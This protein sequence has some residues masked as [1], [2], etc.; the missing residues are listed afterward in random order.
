MTGLSRTTPHPS[1]PAAHRVQRSL[2]DH[3][4]AISADVLGDSDMSG[5]MLAARQAILDK[6]QV[7][8]RIRSA[9]LLALMWNVNSPHILAFWL[10]LH[11]LSDETLL[12]HIQRETGKYVKV[13]QEAPVMGFAV[14][15][16]VTIDAEGLLTNCPL[17]K[18]A[19]IETVRL[20]SRGLLARKAT[21]SFV[22]EARI[23]KAFKKGDRWAIRKGEFIDVPFWIANTD[24][25]SF[26]NPEDWDA[27]RHLE[28][29][30]SG[31]D[32]ANWGSV[33]ANCEFILAKI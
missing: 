5:P 32:V 16:R 33:F 9:D 20:Y 23:D 15:P 13:V 7:G 14:P 27:D 2:L 3:L 18:S 6:H 12:S 30:D 8:T 17:L 1:L 26:S 22:V 31:E 11:L 24:P 29:K 19:F 25:A 28:T 4:D 21:D 10:L